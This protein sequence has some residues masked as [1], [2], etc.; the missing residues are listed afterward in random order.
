MNRLVGYVTIDDADEFITSHFL[1]SSIE[2]SGWENLTDDDKAVLLQNAF[3]SIENN[4]FNGWKTSDLQENQFPRNGDTEVPDD[5]KS[6]QIYEAIENGFGDTTSFDSIEKGIK[7][8]TIGKISTSYFKSAYDN[9]GNNFL[10]S[11]NAK[12]LIKKYIKII[13]DVL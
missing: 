12:R 8:E 4:I 2:R 7:S 1:S 10:K 9:I 5:I 3:D 6:A 11:S 13:F